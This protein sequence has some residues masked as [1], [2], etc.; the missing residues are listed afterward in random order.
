MCRVLGVVRQGFYRWYQSTEG[1]RKKEDKRLL[2]E[3]RKIFMENRQVYGPK[4]IAEHLQ[5]EFTIQHYQYIMRP[6]D[7]QMDVPNCSSGGFE[8]LN[9]EPLNRNY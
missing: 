4:R 8:P 2:P 1:I 7:L 6:T 3:I 9:L 5:P